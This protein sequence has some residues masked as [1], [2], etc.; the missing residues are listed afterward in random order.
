MTKLDKLYIKI[1]NNPK[2]ISF[3]ELDKVLK[4]YGFICRQPSGGSSHYTYIHKHLPDILTIPRNK[5]IKAV[6]VKKALLA[7]EKL[8]RTDE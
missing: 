5:P 4:R 3:E 7:I 2:D 6:Y 8:E 1:V